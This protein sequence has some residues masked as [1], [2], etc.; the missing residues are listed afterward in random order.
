[1]SLKETML[2]NLEWQTILFGDTLKL[3]S[4]NSDQTSPLK[5]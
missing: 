1:M 3:M 2:I 5:Y 4:C